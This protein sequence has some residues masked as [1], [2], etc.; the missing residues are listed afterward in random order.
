[1]IKYIRRSTLNDMTNLNT[2]HKRKV[3]SRVYHMVE[4]DFATIVTT[5]WKA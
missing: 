2:A 4:N 1:M 3:T 5:K